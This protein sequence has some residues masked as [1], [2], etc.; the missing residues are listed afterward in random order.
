[1]TSEINC[2][3][4]KGKYFRIGRFESEYE[5]Y[6]EYEHYNESKESEVTLS[7]DSEEESYITSKLSDFTE[8]Y[9]YV[10]QDCGFIMSFNKEKQVE[11]KRKEKER[12]KKENTYDW[13][14][15]K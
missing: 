5:R 7:L 14:N 12:N 15:F 9:T 1:M 6:C 3:V 8:L 2:L 4:C 13:S 10:C 11:S